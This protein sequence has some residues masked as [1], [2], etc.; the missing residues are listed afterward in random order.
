M[1]LAADVQ[2]RRGRL[3]MPSGVTLQDKH[4][5]SLRMWGVTHVD[6]LGE[7]MEL[8]GTHLDETYTMGATP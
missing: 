3:L 8:L 5:R 6:A 7:A 1:A 4:V 2:D